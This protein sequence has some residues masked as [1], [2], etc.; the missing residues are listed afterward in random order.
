[1]Q[2]S[3]CEQMYQPFANI[4]LAQLTR[5]HHFSTQQLMF[6]PRGGEIVSINVLKRDGVCISKLTS[7]FLSLEDFLSGLK[8]GLKI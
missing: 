4:L 2:D 6:Q 8:N 5:D 1:M 3:I 7:Y